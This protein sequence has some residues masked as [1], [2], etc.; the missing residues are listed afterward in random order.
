MKKALLILLLLTACKEETA[1]IPAP[2]PLTDAALGYFCQM[3]VADHPGPKAQIHLDGLPAPIFFSQVRDAL[4]Y[5]RSPERTAPVVATYVSD[6]GAAGATWED[7]GAGN[8][9][10]LDGATLVVGSDRV[11][12]M[13][14]PEIA[15][16]AE[17][18][19]ADA[20]ISAHGGAVVPLSEIPDEAVLGPVE[21]ELPEA[22]S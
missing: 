4:A 22:R 15:P 1:A 17:R 18:A 16:F 5:L 8:W 3:E 9:I 11:G 2:A 6:M 19:K 20:F 13:G 7:P 12:G 10:L 14:A 21:F